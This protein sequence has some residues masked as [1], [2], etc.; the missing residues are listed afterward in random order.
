MKTI[1]KTILITGCMGLLSCSNEGEMKHAV[2]LQKDTVAISSEVPQEVLDE[3]MQS[4]PQPIEIA[5]IISTSETEI[6][7]NVLIP[8]DNADLPGDKYSRALLLGAYGVDLGYIN[9]NN[10]TMYMIEYL[11]SVKKL[12]AQ[13][14]VDQFFDFETLSKLARNKKNTDSLVEISTENFNKIDQYLREQNRGDQSVLI[15]V[16]AW[17]EGMNM[18]AEIHEKT[19][20]ADIGRRIGEQKVV[21][22]NVYLIIQKL[23]GTGYY[24]Q[25]EKELESV[26]IAYDK[27]KITYIYKKPVMT[28]VNG[29]LVL[30]DQT[31]MK[32]ECTQQNLDEVVKALKYVRN[33]YFLTR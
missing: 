18:L 9:L 30:K 4:L 13:L 28:D 19:R 33:K 23:N 8:G 10:K 29:R 21:F 31:E 25:L 5:Q 17:M 11:E 24:K 12:S 7:K 27:V 16:G 1:V 6:S 32:V 22:D 26:R 3:M 14:K 20:S 15:L 2:P